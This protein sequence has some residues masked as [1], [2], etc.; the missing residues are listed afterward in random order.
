MTLFPQNKRNLF[1]EW[2]RRF[3]K[4]PH[5]L[6]VE[7]YRRKGYQS[8]TLTALL[9]GYALV[10]SHFTL[11]GRI[12]FICSGL[13]MLYAMFSLEMPIHLLAF[14]LLALFVWD[15]VIG[16][17]FRPR[18]RV[19]CSC[20][21]RI[22]IGSQQSVVYRLSNNSK[23][24]LL[25]V[26][27]DTLPLPNGVQFVDGRIFLPKVEPAEKVSAQSFLTA[28][29]RG[30]Y[31]L[32][33]VR[34]DSGYPFGLWRWGA[35]AR[36]PRTLI[37]YPAFTP[38][39]EFNLEAG[40]KYQPNGIALSANVGESMEFVGCREYRYGDDPRRI[41]WRSWARA[42]FPVV[43]EFCE[44]Y[45]CR[46]AL[47]VDTWRPQKFTL[48]MG[49]FPPE[50]TVLEAGLSLTAAIAEHLSHHDYV[51]DL[52]AAG[53]HVHRFRG[54]RSLGF[55]ENILDIL[56]CL[57]PQKKE[58]FDQFSAELIREIA[59]VS[60]AVFVLLTWNQKRS[61]LIR[62][63]TLA[64]IAVKAFL[65]SEDDNRPADLPPTVR[66]LKVDDIRNGRCTA[67]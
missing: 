63:M 51:I 36:L 34:A 12:L 38:L 2:R 66:V 18:V 8:P 61:D 29:R 20:P 65:L 57:E 49:W 35:T 47:I 6:G 14:S 48:H 39:N 33:A 27:I 55:L 11:A 46:A 23:R 24:V 25:D 9:W 5:F 13:I 50:D 16:F 3:Y 52:F 54:G 21:E 22:G 45:L 60:S 64:G 43:K 59:Q 19:E 41:H 67:L 17:F 62:E 1:R 53:P 42:G 58:P 15:F 7:P 44:E 28:T 26:Q 10:V 32:P 31:T 30:R 37:V 40:V 56:A 4:G